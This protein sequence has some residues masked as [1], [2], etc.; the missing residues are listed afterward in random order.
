ME[1]VKNG[2]RKASVEE[3][4]L[5]LKKIDK[6]F[7][8]PI[9][10]KCEIDKYALKLYEK[11]TL[12]LC[13]KEK[14]ITSMVAGYTENLIKNQAYISIVATL[15]EARKMGLATE[16][17]KQFITISQFSKCELVHLYAVPT[18]KAAIHLYQKLGFL[19]WHIENELRPNDIHF[20]YYL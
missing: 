15:P 2:T 14:R 5:F 13:Y 10:E 7:P 3:L 4:K 8:V 19:E 6:T 20:V 11:A 17:V 16:L 12:C 1:M 18:N 9:S